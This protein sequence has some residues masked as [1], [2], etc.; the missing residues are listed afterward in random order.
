[1]IAIQYR[2]SIPRYLALKALG[3]RWKSIYTGNLS[4]VGVRSVERP[5]L[6]APRWLRVKPILSG[7]C[8]SDLATVCAKGSAYFSPLTSTP[9]VLGHET[10]GIVHE[11]GEQVTDF[12]SG[13]RVV[14]QPALGCAVRGIDPPCAA[15]ADGQIALCDNVAGGDISAGIQTGYCRDTGGTW[16][17]SFVAHQSQLYKVPSALDNDIAVLAEPFACA[18]HGVLRKLPADNQQVMV[19][20]CGSIGLLTIAAIR[21]LGSRTRVVAM[22]KHAHQRDHAIALGA[23]VVVLYSS[24]TDERYKRLADAVG[25]DIYKCEI[26]KPTVIGGADVV[27]D[28]VASSESIDDCFRWTRAGGSL[29]LVGMPSIPKGIDWTSAWYKELN[30][31]ASYAY[32][33]EKL[34][35]KKTPT[36]ALA[37]EMLER[38]GHD[39]RPLVGDPFTLHDYRSAIRNALSTGASRSIKTV[40]AIN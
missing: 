1:M 37:L 12:A 15:C 38:M 18:V 5:A 11:V 20:G 28:C 33:V 22:A 4:P 35:G 40:F 16:S 21:A 39:L 30:M 24:R 36:F 10:V 8:G 3:P 6:P 13:D 27:Y 26:G 14:L 32:G 29:V 9:F 25:G 19:M 31:H 23:D 7:S 17:E 34:D 2:K